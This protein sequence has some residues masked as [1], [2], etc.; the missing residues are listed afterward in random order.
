[1]RLRWT[2]AA[3]AVVLLL[4]FSLLSRPRA[5]QKSALAKAQPAPSAP[6]ISGVWRRSRRPPDNAR[7]YTIFEL[8]MSITSEEPPMTP[9][10]MA[11][12]KAN[13]P[14]FGPR[15][16]P[17]S[18]TNDPAMKCFPP[19][20][21]RIYLMRAEPVEIMQI[22]G[23]V[24]MVFEYD[25]FVRQIYTDGRAHAQD[26]PPS[27]M[28]DAIGRWEGDTLVIDTVGFNDISWLDNVGHPHSDQ[29][30]VVE[31][32]RRADHDTLTIDTTIDDPK[33]YT[34][35]WG[36]H[37]ILELKPDWN[38]GEMVCEDDI[39]FSDFQKK[40]EGSK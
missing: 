23:R 29:L 17:L 9:W 31:R 34:K 39:N 10:G 3:F 4:A 2:C 18:Q 28:G 33:T 7:K 38:L 30:H 21:P 35:S 40:T 14:N 36:G 12:F 16:V 11:K 6:D 22:P 25:H 26:P 15:A 5:V 37:A 27:W 24:V 1:M 32:V 8:A 19:G 13:K 20:V